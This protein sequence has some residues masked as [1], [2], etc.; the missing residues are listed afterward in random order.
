M[1]CLQG[2]TKRKKVIFWRNFIWQIHPLSK[3][4]QNLCTPCNLWKVL[5]EIQLNSLNEFNVMKKRLNGPFYWFLIISNNI[6]TIWRLWLIYLHCRVKSVTE[7]FVCARYWWVKSKKRWNRKTS[8]STTP[9]TPPSRGSS[10]S[11]RPNSLMLVEFSGSWS[12]HLCWAC[13]FI[14]LCLPTAIGRIP[15]S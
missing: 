4:S 8:W 7:K 14:G 11:S 6:I 10:T 12:S 1:D 15:P 3:L 2:K 9:S 5:L 13:P